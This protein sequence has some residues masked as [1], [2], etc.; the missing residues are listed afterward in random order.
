MIIDCHVHVWAVGSLNGWMSDRMRYSPSFRLLARRLGVSRSPGPRADYDIENKLADSIDGAPQLDAAVVL[1]VDA[2]YEP[3]GRIDVGRSH[4]FAANDY[5][6]AV[7]GPH[8]KLLFGCSVHPYRKDALAELER[9]VRAGAVLMKWLPIVQDF[10]PADPR[11]FPLYEALAHYRLPLLCH[12]GIEHSLPMENAAV[13]DP[14]RLVP[15]LRRGVTVLRAGE[16]AAV[17]R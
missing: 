17:R 6:A 11:C 1:A 16:D 12:T 10:D 3:D 8:R 4:L 15:A 14:K 2:T 5:V 7:A 9:C 13:G